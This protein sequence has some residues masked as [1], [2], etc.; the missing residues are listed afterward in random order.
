MRDAMMCAMRSDELDFELPAE[1]VAQVPSADRAGSRLLHYRRSDRSVAHRSFAE[2]VDLLRPGDLLVLNDARVAPARFTLVKPT[3]G[4]VEGLL[5]RQT[6]PRRW[7]VMLRNLGPIRSDAAL[8]FSDDASL[9]VRVIAKHPDGEYDIEVDSD[10]PA[11]I[12]LQRLGRMP[13][14]PYIRRQRVH[15]PRDEFDRARYQTVYARVEG[16]IAAPTA[17]LH[18]T[19]ELL[20]RLEARGVERAF[21]TLHV[22]LGTFKPVVV[23]RLEDHAMHGEAYSIDAPAAERINRARREGRRVIAVGTTS[24]RVLE[25]QPSDRP[26][27]PHVGETKLFIM[28]GYRWKRVD[29]LLTNFHLPRSTLIA[30]VAGL[31]GLEEQRRL[32]ALAVERRYRFFSYGDAMF[33]E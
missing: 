19:N 2:L 12:L 16:S 25:S 3:G 17:G 18:F 9:T 7:R 21:V 10:E 23:D 33:V 13:L 5:V 4:Q 31:V 14:P 20:R 22:G 24:A 26:I 27:E 11:T 29:A 1:L 8:R 28:P 6:E 30:L 15:D 32:Y